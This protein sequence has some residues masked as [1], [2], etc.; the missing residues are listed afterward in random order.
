MQRLVWGIGIFVNINAAGGRLCV[1]QPAWALGDET[2]I[3]KHGREVI[4]TSLPGLFRCGRRAHK[5]QWVFVDNDSIQFVFVK[6]Q[7]PLFQCPKAW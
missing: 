5:S 2:L 4:S 6:K 7:N 1:L 3:I